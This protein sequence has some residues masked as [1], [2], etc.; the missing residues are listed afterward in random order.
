MARVLQPGCEAA[1]GGLAAGDDLRI[2]LGGLV[3]LVHRGAGAA[4]AMDL[5]RSNEEQQEGEEGATFFHAREKL[6]G[7]KPELF[8]W[9]PEQN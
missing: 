7:G 8:G 9:T 1:F 2:G 3:P 4:L 5:Q 6:V